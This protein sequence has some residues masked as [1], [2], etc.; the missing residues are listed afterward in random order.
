MNFKLKQYRLFFAI[1]SIAFLAAC[2]STKKTVK[3]N[4]PLPPKTIVK[5]SVTVNEPLLP[6]T[7]FRAV[8]I[9]TVGGIDWPRER[10]D[11]ASQKAWY[12]QMLDT[13][14]RLNV[15]TVF[16]QVRPKADAFYDSP[17]EPWSEYITG[18]RG[19]NPGYDV[20]RW[21]IDET[22]KRGMSFHAWMNPY[23]VGTRKTT[24]GKYDA[25]DPKI[26]KRLIKDYRL[27]RIY[28]PALPETRKRVCDIVRD[29]LSK[30]D[31]DGIHFDDYFYPALAKG[32]KMNDDAEYKRYGKGFSSIE[33]FRRA[34]VDSLVINVHKTIKDVRPSVVFSISPQGNYHNNYHSMYADIAKWSANGW[35]D[36]IIP[37]LYWST[38]RWFRPR[39]KWFSEN[40]AD[41]AH[42]MIG[43]GLYRF[44]ENAK[45]EFYR[46]ADD[47]ALQ[48]HEAY[49]DKNVS[50]A[51]LYSAIWLMK[52]PVN[53]NSVIASQFR[54]PAL[55][56]YLG[57]EPEQRPA[58]PDGLSSNGMTISWQPVNNCYYAVYKDNGNGREASLTAVTLNNTFKVNTAGS[59]FVT[60]VVKGNNAQSQP[61]SIVLIK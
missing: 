5:D 61:S 6:P 24:R 3:E 32:E 49:A 12:R 41:K 15:N 44:S 31:V 1:V 47:L 53:I 25:L 20:L 9:A 29:M 42:L 35:C 26:P 10:F 21:L 50:G 38:E 7:D 28:N 17:Y 8:W 56:P 14:Q 11:E 54:E 39:L 51:V 23:R 27:V 48:M 33:D 2:G 57:Q 16:F 40:A 45:S 4:V 34:M 18:Y 30:Y 22:H 19:K 36:V 58:A 55:P 43:Y 59:Y 13:L 52:N 46:N 60:S 37:Q